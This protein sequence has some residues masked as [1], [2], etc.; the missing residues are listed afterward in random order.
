M[1]VDG[2]RTDPS[3]STTI[4]VDELPANI[5]DAGP[6]IDECASFV[7]ALSAI[8]PS[9]GS[10]YWTSPTGAM[11]VNPDDPNSSVQNLQAGENIF[12]WTLSNG[13]CTNYDAD[14]MVINISMLPVDE[15][16]AGLDLDLCAQNSIYLEAEIPSSATGL[17]SQ[18]DDQESSGVMIVDPSN[19]F[20]EVFGLQFDN[21]YS[22]TWTLSEANCINY[23]FDQVVITIHD[24][25]VENA[26]ILDEEIFTCGEEKIHIQL[27]S[28][29][30]G[31]GPMV[32]G[33]KCC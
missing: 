29:Y 22:F 24:T 15:A 3:L 9:V 8:Q 23:D 6:D 21:T 25:P 4:V 11:V 20:T 5:A 2:C 32:N 16:F 10:G 1:E 30:N 33:W 14:T 13:A 19:P 12:V 7:T 31:I 26:F 27:C 18:S 17:W 28:I